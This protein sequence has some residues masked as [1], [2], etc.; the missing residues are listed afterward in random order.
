MANITLKGNPISTVGELPANGT[1]APNFSLTGLDLADVKLSEFKGKK[2][3][4]NIFPSIDTPI[5]SASVRRFNKDASSLDNTVVLCISRDLPFALKRFCGAEGLENVVSL[6]ELRDGHF[7]K[8]FGV[9]IAD[10]PMQ[11]LLSRAVVVLDTEGKVAYSEQVG[12][13]VDEPN[14]DAAIEAVKG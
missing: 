5:C 10:G 14:Y 9:R 12:E 8:D 11:G 1:A 6:S 13:I 7:G 4:L 3:V 2:V